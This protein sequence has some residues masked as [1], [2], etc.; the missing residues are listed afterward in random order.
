MPRVKGKAPGRSGSGD[1]ARF[2]E[3]GNSIKQHD[4]KEDTAE[5]DADDA[6]RVA[7][8]IERGADAVISCPY[9]KNAEKK[10]DHL[11]PQRASGT[12]GGRKHMPGNKPE[13]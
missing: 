1:P 3:G 13:C 12:N 5:D 7:L 10:T 6:A 4:D 8:R 9:R 11:V 2:D